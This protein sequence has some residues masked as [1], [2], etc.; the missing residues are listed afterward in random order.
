MFKIL[1]KHVTI[2][3]F[4]N[5]H[6]CTFNKTRLTKNQEN[7]A[8]RFVDNYLTNHLAKFLQDRIKPWRAL[9]VCTGYHF[10]QRKLLVRAFQPPL[11][12][13]VFVLTIIIIKAY[14]VNVV[15]D[16]KLILNKRYLL[17]AFWINT[18]PNLL[19]MN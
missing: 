3:Q 6:D 10:F 12:F 11:T 7:S 5:L 1:L 15:V 17:N 4:F 19:C 2:I 14:C 9:R 8:H 16:I 13:H 18:F